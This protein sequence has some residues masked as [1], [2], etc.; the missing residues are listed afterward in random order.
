MYVESFKRS[1]RMTAGFNV[2]RAFR[3]DDADIKANIKKLG[4]F[5]GP[6]L[7]TGG[8]KSAFTKVSWQ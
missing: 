2:Y 5:K 1:G 3:Q 4:K 8:D 7:A 6:V